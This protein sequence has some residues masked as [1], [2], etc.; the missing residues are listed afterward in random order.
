MDIGT[1]CFICSE[2]EV[3]LI[4]K[5]RGLGSGLYN[6]PGGK[7]E[8]GETPTEA[9]KREVR[10]EVHLEISNPSKIGELTFRHDAE[11][12]MF[13][14]VFRTSEYTGEAASSDEARPEWV[15]QD[16]LPYDQ[17]WPDDYLWVPYV[18]DAEPFVATFDFEGGDTLDEATFVDHDI[19][20]QGPFAR[21]KDEP[22]TPNEF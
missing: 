17:M 7:V 3:L 12:R 6:A 5:L 4:E 2:E 9:I 10:E 14:H 18:L 20:C 15:P 13:V 19:T 22:V 21:P 8:V 16:A 11:P 1:L